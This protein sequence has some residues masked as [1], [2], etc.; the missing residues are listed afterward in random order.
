VPRGGKRANA[1]RPKGCGRFGESTLPIRVPLSMVEQV[2][3]YVHNKGFVRPLFVSRISA[4]FPSPADD[5]QEETLNLNDYLVHNP[6]ATFFVRV[7]GD[8][9][10][11]AGIFA[12]DLLVV[13]RSIT[14]TSGR[15]VI[16]VLNGELTVKRLRLQQ[17]QVLLEPE[18]PEYPSIEVNSDMQFEIW[19][20]VTSVVHK[21]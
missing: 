18:N 4:G 9:M 17:Q 15:I 1:G 6:T 5:F 8:S 10:I 14:A 16:A 3:R 21:L 2:Q 12:D 19:G 13:D 7:T 11:G 20:V